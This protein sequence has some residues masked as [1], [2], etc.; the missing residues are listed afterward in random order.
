MVVEESGQGK[1]L[2]V[3]E[4]TKDT[5]N[6]AGLPAQRDRISGLGRISMSKGGTSSLEGQRQGFYKGLT[7]EQG[8]I[9]GKVSRRVDSP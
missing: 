4:E 8:N 6:Q 5:G 2:P 7:G 1:E 9:K 3:L